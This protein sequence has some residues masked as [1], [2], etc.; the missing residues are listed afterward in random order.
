L[1][2][3]ASFALI[4]LYPF[5]NIGNLALADRLAYSTLSTILASLIFGLALAKIGKTHIFQAWVT[6]IVATAL[7]ALFFW[8]LGDGSF[9]EMLK[10]IWEDQPSFATW[11]GPLFSGLIAWF[12]QRRAPLKQGSYVSAT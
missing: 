5:S 6:Y 2:K 10:I 8:P 4:T 9:T 7:G 11:L 1:V 12:I 3:H